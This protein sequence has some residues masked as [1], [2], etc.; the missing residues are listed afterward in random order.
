MPT[1]LGL[2]LGA[3]IAVAAAAH[4]Q[5]AGSQ[6]P[7]LMA[8][9]ASGPTPLPVSFSFPYASDNGNWMMDIDFGDG[10]SGKMQPPP[11]P[12]C[13]NSPSAGAGCPPAGPWRGAHTYASPGT[14]TATLTRGG[15]P[16][17]FTCP[18]PVLGTA[19]I[20]V[21]GGR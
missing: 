11:S 10:S 8:S 13:A 12:P 17:C 21:T 15:L 18:A 16:L 3:T 20:T 14:Y 2:M 4:A 19:T 5:P 9:P 7:S 6:Q 1:A